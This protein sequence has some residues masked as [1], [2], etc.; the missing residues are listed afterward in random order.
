MS[1]AHDDSSR[2]PKDQTH[3]AKTPADPKKA[4]EGAT[5]RRVRAGGPRERSGP[6]G[7]TSG[8]FSTPLVRKRTTTQP[9]G[10]PILGNAVLPPPSLDEPVKAT[11]PESIED[12]PVTPPPE[13]AAA[14]TPEV[15]TAVGALPSAPV[16]ALPVAMPIRPPP[17]PAALF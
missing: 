7:I 8:D 11:A 12:E 5:P 1:K 15:E 16:D 2:A 9:R 17:P 3:G 13:P 4:V 6:I 14:P 10:T